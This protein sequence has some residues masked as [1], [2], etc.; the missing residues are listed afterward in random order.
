MSELGR[1]CFRSEAQHQICN[2]V[3]LRGQL[4]ARTN[5][6]TSA[7]AAGSWPGIPSS[8]SRSAASC[9]RTSPWARAVPT[10]VL[11]T[12]ARRRSLASCDRAAAPRK[13][14][15]SGS[16]RH[17]SATNSSPSRRCRR[18]NRCLG[19]ELSRHL[20]WS[21]RHTTRTGHRPSHCTAM[22]VCGWPAEA[23]CHS[24]HQARERRSLSR[25]WHGGGQVKDGAVRRPSPATA[26]APRWRKARV[27]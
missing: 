27:D 7:K 21:L 17:W 9:T 20:H 22:Q 4:C 1:A 10:S 11:M 12:H 8:A 16:G 23:K 15:A 26:R 19:S 25:A 18:G 14:S 24:D 13:R 5:P 2:S 3:E 6:L